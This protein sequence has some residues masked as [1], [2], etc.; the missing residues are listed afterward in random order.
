MMRI[1]TCGPS[2][3][4]HQ[5]HIAFFSTF[6]CHIWSKASSCVEKALGRFTTNE[7]NAVFLL[8]MCSGNGSRN[9]RK[10]CREFNP[11]LSKFWVLQMAHNAQVL[12]PAPVQE[13]TPVPAWLTNSMRTQN[14]L[15]SFCNY[16]S[17]HHFVSLYPFV[18]FSSFVLHSHEDTL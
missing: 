7:Q 16:I 11:N 12:P 1:L 6:Y 4:L 10:S 15:A 14:A 13:Q 18:Y 8:Q 5:M 17:L 2:D 3:L 9:F